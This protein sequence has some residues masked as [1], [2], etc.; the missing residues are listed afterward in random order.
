MYIIARM[1]V[2]VCVLIS[3][4]GNKCGHFYF[5]LFIYLFIYFFPVSILHQDCAH[6]NTE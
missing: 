4:L 1:Y 3:S 6:F 2:C 5:I